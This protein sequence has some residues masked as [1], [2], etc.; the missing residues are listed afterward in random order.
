MQLEDCSICGHMHPVGFDGDCR[1]EAN[2]Y[3][4]AYEDREE[5][6]NN[7]N[8]PTPG[9]MKAAEKILRGYHDLS[10]KSMAQIIDKESGLADLLMAAK[11]AIAEIEY[12]NG[13]GAV[14]NE[15]HLAIAKAG[16]K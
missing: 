9:A 3:L 2:R 14:V 1:D 16:G 7:M 15:L 5:R 4:F 13:N 10:L 11:E 8:K 12:I 6:V